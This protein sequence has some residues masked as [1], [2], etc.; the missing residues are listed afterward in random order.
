MDSSPHTEPAA[1]LR[2]CAPDAFTSRAPALTTQLAAAPRARSHRRPSGSSPG[3]SSAPELWPRAAQPAWWAVTAVRPVWPNLVCPRG[4][5]PGAGAAASTV[6][7]SRPT[8][9][10]E[11]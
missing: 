9:N 7:R 8:R 6:S 1:R 4:W 3:S 10:A 11:S 2:T 5:R